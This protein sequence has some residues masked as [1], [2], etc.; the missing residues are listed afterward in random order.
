MLDKL[1]VRIPRAAQ[2]TALFGPMYAESR[3]GE[4]RNDRFHET[5]HYTAVGDLGP[6]GCDA[7]LHL[8]NKHGNAGNHKLELLET[9]RHGFSTLGCLI[10]CIFEVDAMKVDVMRADMAVDLKGVPVAFF[11]DAVR[12]A[13]KRTTKDIEHADRVIRIGRTGVETI[14]FGARPNLFR[15][16]NKAAEREHQYQL[17]ERRA[18]RDRHLVP[19]YEELYGHRR[20]ILLTRVERQ[21]GGGRIPEEICTVGA[22]YKNAAS[23]DPFAPLQFC[24]SKRP[25]P[26]PKATTPAPH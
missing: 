25:E 16:Y 13:Y 1:E 14:T 21:Y 7:I 24:F 18:K 23:V 12:A 6:F 20:E 17:L 8:H 4:K 5:R 11:Q 2:F 19:T 26:N 10:E 22:L 15:I 9:G 3:S